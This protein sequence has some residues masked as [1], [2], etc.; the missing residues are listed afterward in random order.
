[1]PNSIDSIKALLKNLLNNRSIILIPCIIILSG[2]ARYQY[3][4][5]DGHLNKNDKQ[6]FIKDNDTVTIN[7]TFKG[8]NLPVTLTIYNKLNQPLY[9]DWD[10][11]VVILNN[12]QVDGPFY[13]DNLPRFIVPGSSITV[14][15][16]S[17]R[18]QF[19]ELDKNDPRIH[20]SLT[21]GSMSGIRYSFNEESTPLFFRSVLA[22]TTNEDYSLPTFYDYSFWVSDIIETENNPSMVSYN[23]PNEFS[24]RRET[25]TGKIFGWTVLI[26]TTLLLGS[27]S[28]GE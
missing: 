22:L 20:V 16:N 28:P 7:Y 10:R 15:S 11:S 27:L 4:F 9:I 13:Q 8:E 2:C 17:L 23:A 1:M 25:T 24:I 21:G 14:A 3:V 26:A 19:I 18:D 12:I 5:V 6:E